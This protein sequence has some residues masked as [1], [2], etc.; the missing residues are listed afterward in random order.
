MSVYNGKVGN[1]KSTINGLTIM[2]DG[3]LYNQDDI[4]KDLADS[5]IFCHNQPDE[6]LILWSFINRGDRCLDI[7][8]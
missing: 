4:I 3:E 1:K 6:E 5:G 2:L 8:D 7:F